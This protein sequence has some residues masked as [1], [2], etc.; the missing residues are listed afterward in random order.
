MRDGW[1][2][3]VVSAACFVPSLAFTLIYGLRSRWRS[4]YV[5][6]S[7]MNLSTTMTIVLAYLLS[8]YIWPDEPFR[9]TLRYAL[10]TLIAVALWWQLFV[11]LKARRE[12]PQHERR[13]TDIRRKHA[14]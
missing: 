12:Q 8:V 9:L 13:S 11:L 7:M 1:E 14:K 3:I 10:L 2:S 5:G 4:N 6:W